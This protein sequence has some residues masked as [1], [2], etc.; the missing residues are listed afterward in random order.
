MPGRSWATL[1]D[2]VQREGVQQVTLRELRDIHGTARLGRYVLAEI[3]HEL[4]LNKILFTPKRLLNGA[5]NDKPR[6]DQV[7]WLTIDEPA[8]T[9]ALAIKAVE[10]AQEEGGRN[11]ELKTL[12]ALRKLLKSSSG[13]ALTKTSTIRQSVDQARAALQDALNDLEQIEEQLK[14]Q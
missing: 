9:A 10:N 1:R 13:S 14:E 2:E 7:L 12:K 5:Y 8:N 4:K 3:A 11:D 6:Q